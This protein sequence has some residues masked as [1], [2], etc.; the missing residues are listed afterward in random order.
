MKTYGNNG[1]A[2][3]NNGVKQNSAL[4]TANEKNKRVH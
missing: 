1:I 2:Y 4:T 3:G